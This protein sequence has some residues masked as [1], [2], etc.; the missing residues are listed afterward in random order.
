MPVLR[1]QV[2]IIHRRDEFRASKVMQKRALDHE[3]IKVSGS[4]H[5]AQCWVLSQVCAAGRLACAAVQAMDTLAYALQLF[6]AQALRCW[7]GLG[8]MSRRWFVLS[9]GF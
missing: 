9:G 3:K 2:Y 6:Q 1:G 5:H 4:L 7:F 8:S